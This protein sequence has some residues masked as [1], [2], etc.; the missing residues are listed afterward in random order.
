MRKEIC[1]IYGR[2]Q[3]GVIPSSPCLLDR[4][5]PEQPLRL[6]E[7]SEEL[8]Q[9]YDESET[10]GLQK[11]GNRDKRK[12]AFHSSQKIVLGDPSARNSVHGFRICVRLHPSLIGKRPLKKRFH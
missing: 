8:H 10:S 11:Q 7:D 9:V 6:L 2:A 4:T 12:I 1:P 3:N 5:K